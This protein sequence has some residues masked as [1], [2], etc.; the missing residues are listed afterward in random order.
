M[1][2]TDIALARFLGAE[3]KGFAAVLRT[4]PALLALAVSG[5]FGYAVNFHGQQGRSRAYAVFGT[6]VL[7]ALTVAAGVSIVLTLDLAR[8]S[9]ILF[10]TFPDELSPVVA[11][12][13][14]LVV[15][16]SAF[17]LAGL[18]AMTVRRPVVAVKA[19][20][21]RRTLFLLV[22]VPTVG[23]MAG[24]LAIA[25]LVVVLIEMASALV[26]ASYAVVKSGFAFG[27]PL[28]A[29]RSLLPEAAK[30]SPLQISQRMQFRGGVL[31]LGAMG[32]GSGAGLYSVALSV[33][34]SVFFVAEAVAA[35]LFGRSIAEDHAT[36][37]R[38]IRIMV[39][40]LAGLAIVVGTTAVFLI[41]LLWGPE[42]EA[43]APV[44][45]L[46]LPGIVFLSL[47]RIATPQAIQRGLSHLVSFAQ[48]SGLGVHLGLSL[49]LIPRHGALGAAVASSVSLG[50]TLG[51]LTR[52]LAR[53][54]ATSV[55]RVL[56][57]TR[58]DLEMVWRMLATREGHRNRMDR[59]YS[60]AEDGSWQ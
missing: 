6:A 35:A 41:P 31:L 56:C 55:F 50:V 13:A 9:S 48:L 1:L 30:A 19:R 2:I 22:A 4:T 27:G 15:I 16:E 51:L 33:G 44:L 8:L 52:H 36:H 24:D 38:A 23:L 7:A 57:P 39:P 10:R 25:L 21:L 49:W 18:L 20:F 45:L 37:G 47:V 43:A 34:Q 59:D 60:D 17:L 58:H 12:G 29:L 53:H 3:G 54:Q 40:V 26:G 32:S 5:G 42:F 46:Q 14:W 11:L 28:A